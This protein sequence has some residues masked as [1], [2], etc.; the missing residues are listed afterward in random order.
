SRRPCT[1][2]PSKA[3]RTISTFSCDIAYSESPT[4]SRASARSSNIRKRV[5]SPPSTVN[6]NVLLALTSIPRVPGCGW[7]A[8]TRPRSPPPRSHASSPIGHPQT[9]TTT[10]PRRPRSRHDRDRPPCAALGTATSQFPRRGNT[11]PTTPSGRAD[12]TLRY[13]A[14]P[15]PRSP[16]TSPAQYL[17]R[18][19]P[20]EGEVW[21]RRVLRRISPFLDQRDPSRKPDESAPARE[22]FQKRP[23]RSRQATK[24]RQEA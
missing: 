1:P 13:C 3:L 17:A 11:S 10:R 18:P 22:W 19:R 14:A 24:N 8:S 20:R 15:H 12:S 16:A 23:I 2:A 21:G 6:K 4:A 7:F 9:S 5:I